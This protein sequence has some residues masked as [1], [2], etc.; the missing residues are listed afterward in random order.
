MAGLEVTS[1]MVFWV[2][3]DGDLS[4]FQVTEDLVTSGGYVAKRKAGS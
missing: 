3:G 1:K 2:T 4:L